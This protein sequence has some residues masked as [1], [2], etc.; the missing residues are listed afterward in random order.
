M[1][2]AIHFLS[3]VA[4]RHQNQKLFEDENVLGSICEKVIIPNMEFR[5]QIS[6]ALSHMYAI[7]MIGKMC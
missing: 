2:H 7:V 6:I 1:S 5:G 3:S 4:D